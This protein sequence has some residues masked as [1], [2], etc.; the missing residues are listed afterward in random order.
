MAQSGPV[1]VNVGSSDIVFAESIH[2]VDFKMPSRKEDFHKLLFVQSGEVRLE[3]K[4]GTSTNRSECG[5]G[6]LWIVPADCVHR[7]IDTKPS[8]LLLL[9]F[10]RTAFENSDLSDGLWSSMIA[11]AGQPLALGTNARE[12]ENGWRR[13][14]LEGVHRD[15]GSLASQR[16]I[17]LQLLVMV[18]RSHFSQGTSA[19][20]RI[21]HLRRRVEVMLYESWSLDAAATSTGL[22]RRQ[23]SKLFRS[24][25]GQSF[26]EFLTEKRL[27]YAE[28]LLR[29]GQ[30]TVSGAAFSAGF[31]DLSHFYRLFRRRNGVPPLHWLNARK[32]VGAEKP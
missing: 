7:I 24:E 13:A 11:L 4:S 21:A 10:G 20:E 30:N 15:I 23:F 5:R 18:A 29:N 1:Q 32:D 8:V 16:A 19:K 25:T 27:D 26:L 22:S 3:W 28:Q 17:A 12:I 2:G 31:E 9:C 6:S 14:I